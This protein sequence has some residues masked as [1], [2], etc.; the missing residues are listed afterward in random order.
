M[1]RCKPH[2]SVRLPLFLVLIA[3]LLTTVAPAAGQASPPSRRGAAFDFFRTDPKQTQFRFQGALAIPA[4]FFGKAAGPF[5]GT[6]TFK[7][8]P[9]G[10]F[11]D[12]EVG[13]ADVIVERKSTPDLRPPFPRSGRTPTELVALS[14]ASVEPITVRAG[15]RTQRWDVRV[16]LSTSRPST[17]NMT[18]TQ[19]DAEKG[20][21][22]NA[23]LTVFPLFI[24]TPQ[25]GG[26]EKRLDV[27]ALKLNREAIEALTIRATNVP[28]LPCPNDARKIPGLSDDICVGAVSSVRGVQ[29]QRIGH[30]GKAILHLISN[31]RLPLG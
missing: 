3:S 23:D 29:A 1:T 9:L 30:I 10:T 28:W 5:K 24:F 18:I 6:V 4:G 22:I 7:G 20:G 25:G 15:G 13:D 31:M 14:L 27:G 16:Q 2:F 11:R 17:G 12:H 19:R 8:V 26:E 21:V